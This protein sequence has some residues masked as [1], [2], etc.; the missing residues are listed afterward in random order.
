MTKELESLTL[1]EP[2]KIIAQ[3]L[4][5]KQTND[6][7]CNQLP[8]LMK[9]ILISAYIAT[10]NPTR[11]D[12]KLFELG[13]TGGGRKSRFTAQRFQQLEDN[14]HAAALKSQAFDLNRLMAIFFAICSE[15]LTTSMAAVNLSQVMLNIRTLKSLHYLQQSNSTYSSLDEPKFKCLVDFDTILGLS[16][17][18]QINIKQ[19][20]AEYI[21]V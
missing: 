13:K 15:N 9:F 6:Q 18:V 12:R 10:H 7:S 2:P 4:A 20:L 1:T 11:Y 16:S 14:Q 21:N 17:S 8:R 5:N 19:Y 3:Q